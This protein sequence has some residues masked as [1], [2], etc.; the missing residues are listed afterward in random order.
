MPRLDFIAYPFAPS[1]IVYLLPGA[2]PPARLEAERQ[3][4]DPTVWGAPGAQRWLCHRQRACSARRAHA[5]DGGF[6]GGATPADSA[7]IASIPL[8]G[9]TGRHKPW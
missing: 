6:D 2:N 7:P 5:S 8:R 1:G 3:G 4:L 9:L